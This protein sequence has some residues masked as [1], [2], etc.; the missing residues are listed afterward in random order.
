MNCKNCGFPLDGNDRFCKNCGAPVINEPAQTIEV[1]NNEQ[2]RTNLNNMNN[3]GV[4][5]ETLSSNVNNPTDNNQNNSNV[6]PSSVFNNI[7]N[8]VEPEPTPSSNIN[9]PSTNYNNLSTDMDNYNN[10]PNNMPNY[11][12]NNNYQSVPN[13]VNAYNKPQNTYNQKPKNNSK[14]I[15]FII[16]GV[17][18]AIALFFG[19][20][21]ISSIKDKLFSSDGGTN[22]GLTGTN[23]NKTYKVTYKDFTFNV[24]DEYIYEITEDGLA[25][26]DELDTW[27]ILLD[28]NS[29]SFAKIKS[30][31]ANFQSYFAKQGFTATA[32]KEAT[33][34]GVEYVTL[35]ISK[36]GS[37]ALVAYSK[38]NSMYYAGILIY[39]AD[40]S[41][42]YSLLTK[43]APIISSATYKDSTSNIKNNIGY[44]VFDINPFE[45]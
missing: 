44:E 10:T 25:I 24:P 42:D 22:S 31:K 6:N 15:I 8:R 41:F 39:T 29:G 27:A 12:Y 40:N 38:L 33:Y 23:S 26:G 4:N 11:N 37:S 9:T 14:V 28:L 32:A 36:S 5:N 7:D 3:V 13:N 35:E 21:S 16:I 20:K 43:L 2:P 19:F 1:S 45:E 34:G 18:V 30:S 17:V